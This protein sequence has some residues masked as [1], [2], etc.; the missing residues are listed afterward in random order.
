LDEIKEPFFLSSRIGFGKESTLGKVN[1]YISITG[2]EIMLKSVIQ[3][4]P[5]HC[6][7]ICQF[8]QPLGDEIQKKI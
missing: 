5:V 3:A 2:R 6:M 4:I 1:P 8:P 7:S